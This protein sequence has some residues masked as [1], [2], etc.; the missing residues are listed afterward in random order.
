MN[1]RSVRKLPTRENATSKAFVTGQPG[2]NDAD[3]TEKGPRYSQNG[4]IP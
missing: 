1:G 3:R 2:Q 4:Y